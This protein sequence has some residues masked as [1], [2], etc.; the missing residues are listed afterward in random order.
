MEA[1]LFQFGLESNPFS[2]LLSL[3]FLVVFFMFY[4]RLM[5]TQIMWRLEKSVNELEAMSNEAKGFI[6]QE[7]GAKNDKKVKTSVN[8]FFE[9][10]MVSPVGLDP[11]GIMRKIE[12]L[13]EGQRERFRHFV[14]QVAPKASAEKQAS[15]EMGLA[16]G[17]GV[18]EIS[19]IVRHYVEMV[20]K[21]KSFQI[22]MIIQMQ[23][24]L[25][26]SLARAVFKGT[27]TLAKGM[28]IGD[29]L[30]P[31]VAAR[32]VGKAKVKEVGEDIVMARKE[33]KGRDV[34]IMKA[35]GPGG[36]LGRP[37]F[38]IDK[39]VRQ[40]KI[41][42]I[43]SVDAAAKLEGERTGSVAE[44]IGVAMGGIG[45]ER[46]Y[47]EEAAMKNKIPLDSVVV[48]MSHEEAIEP[49]RK[50]II[51]AYPRVVEA[52]EDSL[53]RSPKRAKILIIGVGNTSGVGNDGA[54]VKNA[55]EWAAKYTRQLKAKQKKNKK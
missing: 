47:I 5:L 15:L 23:L 19:K 37:G 33:M 49:L 9:F 51:D 32:L 52:I 50:S 53:E 54:G 22:A 16:G 18:Y 4:P 44:G 38:I 12:H 30:G 46:S 27:K 1:V 6:V 29:A 17:I 14:K 48:K 39:M 40:N 36:R 34:F 7:M 24:P 28:P 13:V 55:E 2:F 26:E 20:K 11:Y 45:V 35:K 42:K 21:T 41:A 10:F 3:F 31:Y 25:I 43:I 8:R